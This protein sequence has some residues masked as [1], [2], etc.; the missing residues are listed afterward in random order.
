MDVIWPRVKVPCS[1]MHNV[2]LIA[3]VMAQ[4]VAIFG[5]NVIVAVIV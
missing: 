3:V 1:K 4:N 5:Q 2:L